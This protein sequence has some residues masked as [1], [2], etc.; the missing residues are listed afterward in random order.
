VTC[1]IAYARAL[2]E[3]LDGFDESFERA[4]GEDLDLGTR[5]VAAGARVAWA[6]AALVRHEV[7]T[8]TL[9]QAVRHVG[10]W[11]DAVRVLSLHP[12][13]RDLL[14]LRLFWKPSHPLALVA[15]AGRCRAAAGSPALA[16]LPYLEHHRRR[17]GG[18][19]AAARALP[20]SLVLD[21]A[22]L[23][24]M[25]RGSLRHRTLML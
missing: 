13:L 21:A 12:Q 15:L 24:T 10:K 14:V 6:P 4:C 8:M 2:L 3:R 9:A 1:N 7:R 17:S 16:A 18:L 25:V 20:V 19:R 22:E 23:V 5:A 11:T